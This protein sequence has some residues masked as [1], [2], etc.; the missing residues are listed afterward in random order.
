[1]ANAS[2]HK[3]VQ[4]QDDKTEDKLHQY[5]EH[6]WTDEQYNSSNERTFDEETKKPS[7]YIVY[8]LHERS[9]NQIESDEAPNYREHA[10][11]EDQYHHSN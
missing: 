1:M 11:T 8:P 3:L 9:F 6:A 5:R 4:M 10:W 7:K 2:A